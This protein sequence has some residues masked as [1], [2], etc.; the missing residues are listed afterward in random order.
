M[1]ATISFVT[2][3]TTLA[4]S[5]AA[6]VASFFGPLSHLSFSMSV[7]EHTW[8]GFRWRLRCSFFGGAAFPVYID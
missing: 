8:D 1:I 6:A 4:S 3:Y 2:I 7:S 5:I